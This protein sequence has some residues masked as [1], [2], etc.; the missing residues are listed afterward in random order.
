MSSKKPAKGAPISKKAY[1]KIPGPGT[2]VILPF[3]I[4]TSEKR[5]GVNAISS[6]TRIILI[7]IL[8]KVLLIDSLECGNDLTKRYKTG[9]MEAVMNITALIQNNVSCLVDELR[10]K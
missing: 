7:R 2:G 4:T 9:P 5:R 3:F 10:E 8:K 1:N 6:T